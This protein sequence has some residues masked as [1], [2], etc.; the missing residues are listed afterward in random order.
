MSHV[1]LKGYRDNDDVFRKNANV[2][3]QMRVLRI[4]KKLMMCRKRL[5]IGGGNGITLKA[6]Y[7]LVR[8][9][10]VSVSA[11]FVPQ[12]NHALLKSK[13]SDGCVVK[14]D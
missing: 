5:R 11:Y 3:M 8:L 13:D 6:L 1:S 12:K 2:K 10:S 9:F 7:R 4:Q 14:N